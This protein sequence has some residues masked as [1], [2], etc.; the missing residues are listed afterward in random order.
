MDEV[1]IEFVCGEPNSWQTNL[2][3]PD[4]RDSQPEYGVFSSKQKVN[5]ITELHSYSID[6]N[7]ERITWS[8]DGRVVRTLTEGELRQAYYIYSLLNEI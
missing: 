3:V 8:I 1:D 2:F 7:D 5:S 4:P 6:V